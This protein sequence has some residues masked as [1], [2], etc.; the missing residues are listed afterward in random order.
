MKNSKIF[1]I[2]G[3]IMALILLAFLIYAFNHP[4]GSFP[5]SLEI[6][7]FIYAVY[8]AIMIIMFILSMK[9]KR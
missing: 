5:W 3:F 8:I 6:T 1:G 7:Y 9:G 2:V 4:S